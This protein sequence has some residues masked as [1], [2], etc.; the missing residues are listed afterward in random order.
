MRDQVPEVLSLFDFANPGL[1]TGDREHTNVPSQSLYLLN[2]AQ[3]QSLSDAFAR[4]VY[5]SAKDE[6]SRIINAYLLAFGRP[7]SAQEQQVSRAFFSNYSNSADRTRQ[8]NGNKDIGMYAWSAFCQ[9]LMASAEFR[10]L[11]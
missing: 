5:D 4:R 1:V 8:K 10:Y 9:A 11:N 2:N 3:V 7:A 6:N